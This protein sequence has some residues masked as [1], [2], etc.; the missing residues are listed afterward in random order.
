MI[1]WSSWKE[2]KKVEDRTKKPKR[3]NRYVRAR[4]KSIP[5]TDFCITNVANL[6]AYHNL[7]ACEQFTG[8][9]VT[10]IKRAALFVDYGIMIESEPLNEI[11]VN[12]C[13]KLT[14]TAL[15]FKGEN[16]MKEVKV[17]D[18]EDAEASSR[19]QWAKG[20]S[21]MQITKQA[22]AAQVPVAIDH[23]MLK[24]EKLMERLIKKAFDCEYIAERK[25][26]TE[27]D[28]RKL[29][30]QIYGMDLKIP[31]GPLNQSYDFYGAQRIQRYPETH[32]RK[33]FIPL[34]RLELVEK[35]ESKNPDYVDPK[36]N[37]RLAA[38]VAK[39]NRDNRI[40][41]LEKHKAGT[42]ERHWTQRV[43]KIS[44]TGF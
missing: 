13:D 28:I 32:V 40:A 25:A 10:L 12:D 20:E 18:I 29:T 23:M 36:Y 41:L 19:A 6:L 38:G 15:V 21:R 31:S 24:R 1:S 7:A 14:I 43:A 30:N 44:T 17:E 39:L 5:V 9:V 11:M 22:V 33:R 42:D 2:E 16:T 26:V 3:L 4:F 35:T 8:E 37:W 27:E 34:D